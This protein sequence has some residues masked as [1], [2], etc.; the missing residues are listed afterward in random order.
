VLDVLELASRS[1]HLIELPWH[2]GGTGDVAAGTWTAGALADEFVTR[3]E[4]LQPAGDGP[5]V[6]ALVDGPRRLA[7]L[8]L[9]EGELLR[10]EGPGLPG[11]GTRRPFYLVRARGR[12]ARFVTVLEPVAE[13]PLVRGVRAIG[14]VIEIV[15][16]EGVH[17][18]DATPGGWEVTAGAG[19]IR[20]GGAREHQLP[21]APLLE[22][23]RPRPALGAALRVSEPPP[24]D[25]SADGFDTSEPLRLELEDQYRRSEEPYP[26][27]ED[28]SAV[29]YVVWDDDAL[30]L[31]VA[32]TKPE[33][34]LRPPG[35][36]PLRL[37]NEPDDIHSDGVQ[38]Y[39]R[40]GA[41]GGATGFLV[42]PEGTH[43]GPLRIHGAGDTPGVATAVRGAWRRTR[44]GYCVTLAVGWPDGYRAHVGAELG[45]DLIINEL[46]PGRVRRAGQLVWSGGNGWVW[47]RGDRQDPDRMGVLE[48]VG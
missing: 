38:L 44:P 37:D 15:T 1:D 34:C 13:I 21:R 14:S 9:F 7:A 2:F 27:P 46:T 5:A 48:L 45:F 17:R 23:D 4:R 40:G 30:Y 29:A 39:L 35:A 36:L 11:N 8:L 25:G 31:A 24:L 18:H 19:R 20:L 6:L 12:G 10:A 32:V 16:A 26:G 3:A 43:G 47:L 33:L 22:I 42:V 28:F 41:A